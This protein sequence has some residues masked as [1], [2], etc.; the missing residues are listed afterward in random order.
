M[1]KHVSMTVSVLIALFHKSIQVHYSYE[2]KESIYSKKLIHLLGAHLK[3]E[4]MEL[5]LALSYQSDDEILYK[6]AKEQVN[7]AI[8]WCHI[9]FSGVV[10][11]ILTLL[12]AQ[13]H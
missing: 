3:Q 9:N 7:I 1:G 4:Q 6:N 8:F 5:V 11:S 10:L 2:N 13:V 12:P